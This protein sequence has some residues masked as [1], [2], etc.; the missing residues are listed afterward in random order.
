MPQILLTCGIAFLI[1]YFSIP[2]IIKIANEKK[3]FDQPDHRKLHKGSIA[4]LGGLGIF[5]GLALAVL[6]NIDFSKAAEFQYF[7]AAAIVIFF[8]GFKDD[9]LVITP[10]KKLIGQ[11][12]AAF[13]IIEKG[14]IR[15]DNMFGFLGFYEVPYAVSTLL[16]YF[17]VVLIINAFNLIDGIDG[18]AGCLGLIVSL[19]CGVYFFRLG[20]PSYA[21]LSFSLAGSLIAFLLFN[22]QPAKIFMGDTGSMLI[23]L[24][25]SILV[26]KFVNVGS[27]N[28]I[29]PTHT[30][31]G[32]GF[33]LLLIPI[34]DTLR[35]FSVRIFR[36][37]SPFSADR[38]HIHHLLLKEGHSH[39]S[40]TFILSGL[41]LLFIFLAFIGSVLGN[42]GIVLLES[43]LFFAGLGIFC[44]Y[45]K[46]KLR[47]RTDLKEQEVSE[48]LNAS[49]E[50][51]V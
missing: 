49:F 19:T 16:T 30:S 48:R 46:L 2:A 13:F 14:G 32:L 38:N 17:A 43:A 7:I 22:F 31:L 11:C 4:P 9:V 28:V 23:G 35:V 3:L 21:V 12:L 20:L 26:I 36:G 45:S 27:S 37:T 1:T 39:K 41:S 15:V 24:V 5:A 47:E 42:T 44:Y 40:V 51:A 8:L 6:T 50:I 25:S 18:L 33:S 29:F 34:L 10:L